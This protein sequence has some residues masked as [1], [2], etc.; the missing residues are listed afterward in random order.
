MAALPHRD[1]LDS[2]VIG[3]LSRLLVSARIPM[4]GSVTGVHQS[5]TRGSSVE[6]AEYRKYVPGDEIRHLDW[7]VYARSDRFFMKEFEADTNL[8][9]Y[10]VLDTSASMAYA[11][12]HGSKFD[13]A[14]R[15]IATLAHLLVKQGDAVGVL[16]FSDKTLQEIPARRSPLHLKNIL[17]TL[18]GIKP[19]GTTALVSTLHSLA[20]KIRQRALVLLFSDCFTEVPPLLDGFQHMRYRKH[21]LG[22]FHLLDPQEVGFQFD[23]PTRFV[24]LESPFDLITDPSVIQSAYR[25][26]VDRYLAALQRGCNEFAVD[27]QRV[28]LTNDYEKVLAGF[29]LQRMGPKAG[30]RLLR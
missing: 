19:Q 12:E 13:Y 29:L 23:R 27:Y 20:E 18:A 2:A 28:L 24:D 17:D 3:R 15:L 16:C 8:R 22:V 21:D 30:G 1:F 10:L 5:A 25:E 9:C 14:R 6:F 26:E 11:G 4:L 7:R